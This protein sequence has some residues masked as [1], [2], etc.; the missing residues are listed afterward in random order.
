MGAI[1]KLFNASCVAADYP[2]LLELLP[3]LAL[4]IPVP[5][6]PDSPLEPS[7]LGL[8]SHHFFSNTTTPVFAFD[9][10]T[11]PELGRVAAQKAHDSVAPAN[12]LVGV[13]GKG[14][15]AVPWLHI[16]ARSTTE[17]NIKAVYRLTTAGGSPPTSCGNQ[18]SAISVDYAAVYWFWA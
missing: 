3:G 8:S 6:G 1:A 7:D 11:G 16:T 9:V 13:D 10:S 12:A 4:S 18:G 2:D 17:G 5:S 14:N 15:G